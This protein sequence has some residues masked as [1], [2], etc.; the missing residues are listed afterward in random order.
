M[1]A[2]VL[3]PDGAL[4][5]GW[6]VAGTLALLLASCHGCSF[7]QRLAIGAALGPERT[8]GEADGGGGTKDAPVTAGQGAAF[9]H[10]IGV[11]VGCGGG[12]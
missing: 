12:C 11:C 5:F 6:S 2:H 4:V 1:S 3:V 8:C 9:C 10:D 7:V